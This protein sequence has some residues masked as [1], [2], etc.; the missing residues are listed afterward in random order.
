METPQL[1]VVFLSP[2]ECDYSLILEN[3]LAGISIFK[4]LILT[5][6]KAGIKE[7]LVLSNQLDGKNIKIHQKDV[8]KDSRFKNKL[9][10][11]DHSIFITNHSTEQLNTLTSSKHF[12]A[13][14]GNLV[15]HHNVIRSFIESIANKNPDK[16]YCLALDKG[17]LGG[18]YL[19]PPSELHTLS[20]QAVSEYDKNEVEHVQ[21][22]ADKN[23]WIEVRDSSSV[24]A[25]ENLL[26]KS[27]GLNNDS[28][29]DR[30]ITRFLSRQF[31]RI[32]LKT[33]MTP[34]QITFLSLMIGLGSAWYF[35]QGT[36]FS[37]LIGSLLLLI[38]AWVDCTDGEIARLKFMETPWGARFDIICDNIVHCIVFFSIGM[39]VFFA[40][41][42]SLYILYGGLAVF[43]SLASF[44]TLGS[45]I[46]ENKQISGKGE[47]YKSNIEDQVANRDFIYF[48]M[49]MGCIGR[50]DIFILLTAIGANL[51]AFYLIYRKWVRSS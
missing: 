48:L 5:L 22:S 39:G 43:G 33:S 30:L 41:E 2:P 3:K 13:V 32:L 45:T 27:G 1:A 8:E 28:F 17:K 15:T 38:S 40:T 25:T 46:M 6:Q 20:H 19:L 47:T 31:T 7:I 37:G 24:S 42:D 50:L 11:Y 9:L 16:T 12:L 26:L 29:M 18:M 21:L 44:M 14:N 34:N 4:R 36:Y 23:F 35:Y 49:V 51:F 10:W